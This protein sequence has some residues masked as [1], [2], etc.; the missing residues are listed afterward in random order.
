MREEDE[1]PEEEFEDLDDLLSGK[2]FQHGD[3]DGLFEGEPPPEIENKQP[4]TLDEKEVKVV[5]V[6]EHIEQGMPPAAF[7][8]LRDNSGRQVLIY[9]GRFE[10]Y[11]IS[12]ALE[13]A[14][15]DRP[16]THDLMKNILDR[17]GGKVDRITIDDL[18]QDTYYAKITV[19]TNGN[20]IDI[21]AR[22]SDAIAL[23]LRAKAPIYMAESVLQQATR[24][25]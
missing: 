8:L 1:Q 16:M 19:S 6:Y 23:A 22:P 7:V 3:F 9:I 10:A 11:A 21:D 15:L 17:L 5:G 18:W 4:R 24:E 25:D 14:T 12:V 2:M 13:G 20:F